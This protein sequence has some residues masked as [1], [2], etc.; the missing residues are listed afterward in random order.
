MRSITLRNGTNYKPFPAGLEIFYSALGYLSEWGLASNS[1]QFVEISIH[2]T[3]DIAAC[4]WQDAESL[5]GTVS[6]PGFFLRAVRNK[7]GSYTFH[8]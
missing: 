4:Y 8:S 2:S 5:R 1:Y 6:K 7:D 3:G